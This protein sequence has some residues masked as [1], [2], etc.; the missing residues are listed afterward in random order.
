MPDTTIAINRQLRMDSLVMLDQWTADS[1]QPGHEIGGADYMFT[2][3]KPQKAG[4]WRRK[5]GD[6]KSDVA[7][8]NSS[9]VNQEKKT[10][11]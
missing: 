9:L 3:I 11:I 8:G 7:K 5:F 1:D 4:K 2:R 6:S 10:G